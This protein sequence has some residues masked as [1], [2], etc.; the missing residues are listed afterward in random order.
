M[1]TRRSVRSFLPIKIPD[2]CLNLILESAQWAPSACNQQLWQF[3]IIKDNDLKIRLTTEAGA[4][5]LI[6]KAPIAIA[7]CYHSGNIK[8]GIQSASAAIENMLLVATSLGI[9]SLYLNS[10]GKEIK[11]K[12]IL[13]IPDE[14]FIVAFILLGYP[15]KQL[16]PPK[17]RALE[18]IVHQNY[19]SKYSKETFSHDANKWTLSSVRDFQERYCRKTDLGTRMDIVNEMEIKLIQNILSREKYDNILDIFSYDGSL[20]NNY[21]D[22]KIFSLNLGSETSLFT[23]YAVN[24]KIEPLI[25]DDFIP[26]K[27]KSISNA[28]CVFKL[29]RIPPQAYD[30]LFSEIKRV[31]E[32]DGRF[33][34]VFRSRNSLYGL[35]HRL[36]KIKFDD[37]IR[38]S[39]IYS[40]F[41]PYSPLKSAD[42]I[43]SLKQADFSSVSQ[44]RF[45][46]IPPLIDDFYQ[47]FLHYFTSG[48]GAFYHREKRKSI[49]GNLIHKI[50]RLQ[51]EYNTKFGS[52]IVLT[53]KK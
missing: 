46:V 36:I 47:L 40:F 20:L 12:Q 22:M 53:A 27:D 31:L 26:L 19:F 35:I 16:P 17:R 39:G 5:K 28:I 48:G 42:I 25:Y 18:E 33:I 45:F 49:V 51:K 7:V 52:V 43:S 24:R 21:P 15:E 32:D 4:S 37:D 9:G 38:K 23:T 30:K 1:K 29:E 14:L 6:L 13:N 3:I 8:E 2:D 50:I 10:F 41:G 11:V 44:E 34:I